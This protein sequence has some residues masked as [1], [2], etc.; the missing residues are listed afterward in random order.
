MRQGMLR[1]IFKPRYSFS[2]RPVYRAIE[3]IYLLNS[4]GIIIVSSSTG[5][6]GCDRARKSSLHEKHGRG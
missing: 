2:P 6:G 1:E 5:H 4:K 3:P